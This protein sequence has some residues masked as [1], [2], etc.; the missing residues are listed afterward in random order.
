MLTLYGHPYSQHAR[1]VRALLLQAGIPFSDVQVD[2]SA[3]AQRRPEFLALNPDGQIPVLVDGEFVV[4]ESNAILRYLCRRHGLEDWYPVL[5]QDAARV[6]EWL[7]WNQSRLSGAIVDVVL[8][9][10]FLA[11]TGDLQ[12]A[13]RGRARLGPL[14]E[15]LETH[16]K[17]RQYLTGETPTIA[18]LS[19]ATGVFHLQFAGC[20]LGGAAVKGWLDRMSG[21]DGMARSAPPSLAMAE[22]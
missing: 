21:L 14:G 19:V 18:D 16:L 17:E 10:V 4:R 20:T 1:R 5:P 8:N 3:G 22:A 13:E 15:R 9:E 6:D 12:A 7:D 11:P 2:L